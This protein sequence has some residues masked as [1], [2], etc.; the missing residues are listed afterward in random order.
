MEKRLSPVGALEDRK[1][2]DPTFPPKGILF[3]I[4]VWEGTESP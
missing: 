1:Y 4:A 3:V 2:S